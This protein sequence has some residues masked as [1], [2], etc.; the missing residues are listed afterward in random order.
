VG[1]RERALIMGGEVEIHGEPGKGTTVRA[2]IP[3][4]KSDPNMVDLGSEAAGVDSK[5]TAAADGNK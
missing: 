5:E 3:L 2:I 1:M 4:T